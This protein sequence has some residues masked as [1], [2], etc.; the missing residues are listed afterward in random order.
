MNT[1]EKIIG[2]IMN[3]VGFCTTCSHK[4]ESWDN[5]VCCPNCGSK[6]IPC[7]NENQV[8]ISINIK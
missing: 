3:Y 6:G 7:G 1:E 8:T 4:I 2:K 5:L